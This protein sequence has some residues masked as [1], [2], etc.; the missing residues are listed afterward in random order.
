MLLIDSIH[1]G[2]RML[3]RICDYCLFYLVIGGI[4]LSLPYF[5]MPFFYCSLAV[6]TP[7]L[8]V[9]LEALF[10]SKWGATPGKFLF[11]L[12]VSQAEGFKLSYKEALG[13]ALHLPSRRG[14]LRQRFVSFKRKLFAVIASGIIGF[15]ALYGNALALWSSGLD[16]RQ[17]VVGW[18]QY[19][20][21]QAGFK[22]SFPKDPEELSQELIIP[23]GQPLPYEEVKSQAS[24]KVAYSVS[25]IDLPKKWRIASNTTLLKGVLDLLVKHSPDAKLIEKEFGVHGKYRVL[26]Y[27][28][29]QGKEEIQGRLIITGSATL[30]KI[31]V[32]YPEDQADNQKIFAF[33]DSFEVVN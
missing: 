24:R 1:W 16:E 33:L 12:S 20:S 21:D 32:T 3:S 29:M 6:A 25:Y 14:I 23:D 18:V 5:Y 28:M 17:G 10:L 31:T 11:G 30:Y 2:C 9:P 13:W 8:W 27:R 7:L 15:S 26:D 19:A 4:A 22:I